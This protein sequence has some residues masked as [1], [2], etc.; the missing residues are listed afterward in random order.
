MDISQHWQEICHAIQEGVYIVN[1][2]GRIVMVNDA[3]TRLTGYSREELM[4]KSCAVLGCEVCATQRKGVT[5]AWC[6]LFAG[7]ESQAKRCVIRR[8]DGSLLPVFKNQSLIHDKDGAVIGAVESVMD[9]SELDRLDRRVEELSRLLYR[10]DSFHGMVGASPAMRRLFDILEKAARSDA[11]VLLLGESGTGKELA[12]RA[13]HE[14]GARR[15]GPFVQ[16]NCAALNESLLESELFGHAKGAFTGA[17][18]ERQGRFEAAHSGDIFLDE[19]GDAPVS[20]QVKLLRVLETRSIERV[21]ANRPI[22]VDVRLITATHQDLRALIGQGRFRE[23]FFFRINVIPIELPPLRE[24]MEDLPLLAGHFLH[25]SAAK[26]GEDAARISPEAMRLL[27]E[28]SWPGNVR[29][30]RSALEYAL[31]LADSGRIEASHLPPD[32]ARMGRNACAPLTDRSAAGQATGQATGQLCSAA[33]ACFAPTAATPGSVGDERSA[34]V[35]A[36]RQTGGNKSQAARVLGVSRL[37]V[38]NRMRKHGVTCE[39]IVTS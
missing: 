32:V 3:M 4:E 5:G 9:L 1:P 35:E 28:H 19:I 34:L 15:G 14:L 30:L 26:T 21:G 11:P 18:R 16:L 10:P 37:T 8:K 12:A 33:S 20:I 13:I 39:R 25:A 27:M 22:P 38:L 36:L 29:E 31:V 7:R 2:K 23:D 24:R 6:P 17:Y